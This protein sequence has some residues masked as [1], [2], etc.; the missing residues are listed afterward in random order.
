MVARPRPVLCASVLCAL[1]LGFTAANASGAPNFTAA[2]EGDWFDGA[3]SDGGL[4]PTATDSPAIDNGGTAV[5]SSGSPLYPGAVFGY[6][7]TP[8]IATTGS[9]SVVKD[10]RLLDDGASKDTRL[11]VGSSTGAFRSQGRLDVGGDVL[12]FRVVDV[13]VASTAWYGDGE[14]IAD[15]ELDITG[16]LGE[17]LLFGP[18]TGTPAVLSVGVTRATLPGAGLASARGSATIGEIEARSVEVGVA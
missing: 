5:A 3:S 17:A 15:G 10:L 16:K 1:A 7:D 9:L 2:T 11:A 14:A 18:G 12:G 6:A 13:G 8:A 4:A